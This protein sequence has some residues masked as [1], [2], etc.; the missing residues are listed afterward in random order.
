MNKNPLFLGDFTYIFNFYCQ[1]P[2]LFYFLH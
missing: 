1:L 2:F